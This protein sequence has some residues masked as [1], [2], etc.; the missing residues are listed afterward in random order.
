MNVQKYSI[1]MFFLFVFFMFYEPPVCFIII[2]LSMLLYGIQYFLFFKNI[3]KSGIET[4]GRV[5]KY[6]SDNEGYKTP[7]IEFK[8]LESLEV[9]KEPY[10]YWSTDLSKL[11]SYKN[12]INDSVS[13]LYDPKFPEK[14]IILKENK[15]NYASVVFLCIFALIFITIG[16]FHLLGY[17]D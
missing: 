11:R 10:Y 16:V 5:L 6:Q 12:D 3:Q 1:A 14:F 15:S 17:M 4:K 7:I 9:K 2:G 8:T 13:V